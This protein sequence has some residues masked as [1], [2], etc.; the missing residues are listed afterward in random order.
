[1]NLAAS[2]TGANKKLESLDRRVPAMGVHLSALILRSLRVYFQ[3]DSRYSLLLGTPRMLELQ[4]RY[5]AL[6]AHLQSL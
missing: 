1:M 4:I 3:R 2:V 6:I 5:E